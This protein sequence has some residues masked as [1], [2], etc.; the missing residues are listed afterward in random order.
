[1][2][3][4]G[5]TRCLFGMLVLMGYHVACKRGKWRFYGGCVGNG[6]LDMERRSGR[7][8]YHQSIT[9]HK[10]IPDQ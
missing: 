6:G 10:R 4:G 3:E 9:F 1:M 7:E 2:S 8:S 5:W